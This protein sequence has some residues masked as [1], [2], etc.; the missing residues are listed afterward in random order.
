MNK[1]ILSLS[2]Y[3]LLSATACKA[4]CEREREKRNLYKQQLE[5]AMFQSRATS[6]HV[7]V[8][9]GGGSA[10]SYGGMG[11]GPLSSG[12]IPGLELLQIRYGNAQAA[13]R[14]CEKGWAAAEK[15]ELEFQTERDRFDREERPLWDEARELYK[16]QFESELE[17]IHKDYKQ[18]L[19]KLVRRYD[20]NTQDS[21]FL[22]DKEP[23]KVQRDDAIYSL[24]GK[25]NRLYKK[26]VDKVMGKK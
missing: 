23:L 17:E 16:D 2:V 21:E 18:K 20:G 14:K 1:L 19:K 22:L 5:A 10:S 25:Y 3:C 13:L 6:M 4:V 9:F 12:K 26:H 8:R 7:G 11:A 15:Q 24:E